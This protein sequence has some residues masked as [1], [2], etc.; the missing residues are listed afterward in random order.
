[1]AIKADFTLWQW[2]TNR[3]VTIDS[4]DRVHF[5]HEG[6][7]TA[8]VIVP[9]ETEGVLTAAIPDEL[10]QSASPI[11]VFVVSGGNTTDSAYLSVTAR[12]RPNDYSYTPTDGNDQHR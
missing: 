10:L 6:D 5:A 2:D 9:E 11:M 12:P 4:G 8:Y 7:E 1:M 3:S